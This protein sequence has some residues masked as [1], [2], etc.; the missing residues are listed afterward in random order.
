MESRM[1][2]REEGAGTAE[3]DRALGRREDPSRDA[4]HKCGQSVRASVTWPRRHTSV[5][6]IVY[7]AGTFERNTGG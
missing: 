3:I 1:S 7:V 5:E 4:S 2:K 6:P